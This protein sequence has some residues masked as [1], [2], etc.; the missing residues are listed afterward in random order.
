MFFFNVKYRCALYGMNQSSCLFNRAV[1]VEQQNYFPI[2][3]TL[4]CSYSVYVNYFECSAVNYSA[5]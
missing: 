1:H 2:Y 4:R 3:Y 5:K